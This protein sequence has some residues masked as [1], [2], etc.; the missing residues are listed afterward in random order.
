MR[1]DPYDFRQAL[2]R[3]ASGVTIVSVRDAETPRGL[4]VSA[5]LSLSL[6]PPL[7]GVSIDGHASLHEPVSRVERFGVSVL[8]QDQGRLSDYFANRPVGAVADPFVDL[9][10]HPVVG[11]ALAQLVC[12]VVQRVPTGDHTF[13]VGEVEHVALAEG[14]PLLYF[15]SGYRR[16]AS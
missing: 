13:V 12:R 8:A 10:G 11:G 3:F 16:L 9:A 7:V 5:F 2:G 14:A 4:T 1:I 6:T 15:R